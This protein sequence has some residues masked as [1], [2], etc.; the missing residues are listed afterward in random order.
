MKELRYFADGRKLRALYFEAEK[1][2]APLIVDIHGGAFCF[3]SADSDVGL[4]E[5]LVKECGFNAV[6]LDYRLAPLHRHP[7][8]TEDCKTLTELIFGDGTLHFDRT[9]AC[10]IGHSAGANLALN[11]ALAT[12]CF[13][14][15]VLDYPWMELAEN[16]RKQY[17]ASIP[18]WLLK[19]YATWY[20]PG[21]KRR[22]EKDVSP[23]YA[24]ADCLK[25]LPPTLLITCGSDSLRADGIAFAE[26][27]K[28]AGVDLVHTEYPEAR[29]GFVEIVSGDRMKKNVYTSDEDVRIQKCCYESALAEIVKF[30]RE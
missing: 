25:G 26:K 9:K 13:S 8:Q 21:K 17:K 4:C 28:Q 20:C 15:V 3:G 7:A 29:H 19:L 22:R 10:V 6:S 30:V 11:T 1:K 18:D 23:V 12:K 16:D 14:K 27:L 2:N 5:R 24:D